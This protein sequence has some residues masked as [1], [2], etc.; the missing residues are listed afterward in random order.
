MT[1]NEEEQVKEKAEKLVL[2]KRKKLQEL[3]QQLITFRGELN[4]LE[5]TLSRINNESI[6]LHN[7][8]E[9]MLDG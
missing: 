7:D 2:E 9:D 8:I 3:H 4:E 6:M 5:K 1:E